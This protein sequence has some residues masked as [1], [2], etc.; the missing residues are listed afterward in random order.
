MHSLKLSFFR[1]HAGGVSECADFGASSFVFR[2]EKGGYKYS[3]FLFLALSL[4]S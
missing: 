4:S 1:S 2:L 3:P